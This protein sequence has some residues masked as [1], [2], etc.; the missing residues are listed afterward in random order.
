MDAAN[1]FARLEE[2]LTAVQSE[3]AAQRRANR[4]WRCVT[5][6]CALAVL[7]SFAPAPGRAVTAEA[8]LAPETA[9][10]LK[11]LNTRLKAAEAKIVALRAKADPF[12]AH[13]SVANGIGNGTELVI[14]GANLHVVSGTGL[15]DGAVNG[16]GNLIVGYN[17]LRGTGDQR[18]GSHNLI[19]GTRQ[20]Y[21]SYG[22]LA[23]GYNS[24]VSGPYSAVSGG[25][26]NV[27]NNEYAAVSGGSTNTAS[28]FASSASGGKDNTA[29]GTYSSVSAGLLNSAGGGY[30]SVSGGNVNSASGSL[31][32]V[33]GGAGNL[34][35]GND[36]N[37]DFTSILGGTGVVVTTRFGHSP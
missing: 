24:T 37:G 12:F 9:L 8:L 14:S 21:P 33:S 29:S 30:A 34:A 23:A 18:D 31:S 26:N 36:P 35:G 1:Q 2:T 32:A 10:T 25:I 5:A 28:G 4:R 16:L 19:V 15:T 11:S 6:L 27:A 20:N 17:E 22:C 3:L 7:W 13:V